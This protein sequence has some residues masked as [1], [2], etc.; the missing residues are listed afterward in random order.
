MY[1]LRQNL[2]ET[3][4]EIFVNLDPETHSH[5]KQDNC[6]IPQWTG[7]QSSSG[8]IMFASVI[9]ENCGLLKGTTNS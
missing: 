1:R 2:P 9:N 3:H 5:H 8:S 4:L 7:R 6:C